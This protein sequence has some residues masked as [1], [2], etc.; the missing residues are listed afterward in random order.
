[1]KLSKLIHKKAL[2]EFSISNKNAYDK[3]IKRL[4]DL[5]KFMKIGENKIM[6]TI[7]NDVKNGKYTFFDLVA[8]AKVRGTTFG[9][10][11]SEI[12]FL[13]AY[14]QENKKAIKRKEK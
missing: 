12:K 3:A 10:T 4:P 8:A 7:L 9:A 6:S 1:M 11:K 14:I 2:E 13:E 5:L